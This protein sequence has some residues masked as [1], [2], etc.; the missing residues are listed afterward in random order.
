MITVEIKGI[1]EV[2]DS[3]VDKYDFLMDLYAD[4]LNLAEELGEENINFI[5]DRTYH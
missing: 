1:P 5:T 2:F 3:I 4:L